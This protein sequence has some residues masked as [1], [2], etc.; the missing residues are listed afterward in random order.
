MTAAQFVA[1][2][3]N[4]SLDRR[5]LSLNIVVCLGLLTIARLVA[6]AVIPLTEDE[7]YYLLWAQHLSFGYFDH[8]PMVA[9][10]IA[11]GR[12][13][14]GDTALGARL[15][16]VFASTIVSLV[17]IDIGRTLGFAC[18]AS[19]R[20][21]LW[22]NAMILIGLGGAIV[23]PDAP[24]TF[25]W[26]VTLWALAKA[27][28][29]GVGAWWIAAG[30][31]AGLATLS[32]YSALFIGPG[33]L[34]W[35]L[36]SDTGRRQLRRPWPWLALLIAGA[37]FAPNVIWNAN[38]HWLSFSKQFSRVAPSAFTP[39][40]VLDFPAT[41]F[42]LLNPLI[43]VFAVLGIL[44]VRRGGSGQA[45]VLLSLTAAPFAVYLL[46]HSL[47]AG[48]QAHWPAPLYPVV[49]LL[50]ASA[51][52]VR[53]EPRW[54]MAAAAAPWVGFVVAGA[55]LLHMALPQTD[56]F[57]RR[58]PVM[59]LRG[60]AVFAQNIEALRLKVGAGW[61]GTFSYG[62]AAELLDRQASTAPVIEL[63]ERERYASLGR[64]PSLKGVGLVVDL[65]RRLSAD[66][67][68]PCF[69]TLRRLGD[70]YRGDAGRPGVPYTVFLVADPKVD[71]VKQGCRAGKDKP[72]AAEF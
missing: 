3:S 60:W 1:T 31:A 13:F 11:L 18:R 4:R 44:D 58:D 27:W 49:A 28:R 21:G 64:P 47:H 34:L 36:S 54:R 30:L 55:V 16:A 33:V 19:E 50:A 46:L 8:P 40:H 32:K 59:P 52:D 69:G 53:V 6:A 56:W 9:W 26:T 29:S 72:G 35:L 25:F 67:L 14:M 51:A 42:L 61:V 5:P 23:T 48:V 20:A 15:V 17:I 7:A 22:Y 66:D 63:I 70:L 38:H 41:Q 37:V 62:G 24:A 65:R 2:S 10:W 12:V 57:G 39:L 68:S 43:A 71:L 45:T